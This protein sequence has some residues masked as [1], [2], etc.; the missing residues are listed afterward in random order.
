MSDRFDA[1]GP[2]QDGRKG[3]TEFYVP[4]VLGADHRVQTLSGEWVRQVFMDNAASTKPFRAVSTFLRD[5]EGYYSNIHRGTGFDSA[6]CTARYEEARR[7]VKAFV[8]GDPNKDI[9]VPVRNTTEGLNLLANTCNT[10]PDEVV[11]ATILEHHSNDLPWRGKARVEYVGVREDDSLAVEEFEQKLESLEGKVKIVAVTGASNVTGE[12]T[13]IHQIAEAAHRH[14]A[15]IVVDA[16]Q[17]APHRKVDMLPHDHPGHLD[18]VVFSAHKMNSPYGEGAIVGRRDHFAD[19]APYLQGG[20]TV[21]LVG[22]D[23]VVWADPPDKQEAGTPNILG[24]F[25]LASAIKIYES[26]GMDQV[27]EHERNLTR[28][29]LEGFAGIPNTE[30]LGATD[31]GDLDNRLGV[32]SFIVDGVPH[33]L[34][35][36]VLSYEFG[37]AVRSGCFCAHP[38][39]KELLGVTREAEQECEI[40]LQQKDRRYLPGAVRASV[41]LHNTEEDVERLLAGMRVVA[42][43]SWSGTYH[44]DTVTGEYSPE[45]FTFD[46]GNCPSFVC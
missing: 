10:E 32:L 9:V 12:V 20:G 6:L 17:L 42:Q 29:L 19:A 33:Q 13:P 11:L 46:F 16:A 40:R 18:F 25:A 39:I 31:T 4:E 45:G 22:L 7:I 24:L 28:K 30:V 35:A 3:K 5:L 15:K 8:N 38:L 34:A 37:I 26:I 36:A 2:L 41:G 44:Q 21:F 43:R 23:H 27:A 1:E 14:G